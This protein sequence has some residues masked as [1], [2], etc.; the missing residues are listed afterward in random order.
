MYSLKF[1]AASHFFLKSLIFNEILLPKL[2][3]KLFGA[4][5]LAGK[6]TIP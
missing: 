6:M 4:N 3:P 1:L 5:H 2:V